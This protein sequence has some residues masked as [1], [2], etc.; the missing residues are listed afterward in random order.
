MWKSNKMSEV[1]DFKKNNKAN[2]L[3]QNRGPL[4]SKAMLNTVRQTIIV[5]ALYIVTGSPFIG[6]ELWATWDPKAF[7]LPFFTGEYSVK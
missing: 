5:I 7:S 3:Q 6:C 4:I 2:F 1:V